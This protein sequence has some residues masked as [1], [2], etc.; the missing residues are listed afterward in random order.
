MRIIISGKHLEITEAIRDYAEKKV[1]KLKKYFD[2]IIEVD[3]TLSVENTKSEGEKHIADVLIF[4]NGTKL[5]AEATDKNLYASIDEVI[6]VLENQITKYKEKL[7]DN[8]HK[9]NV[10]FT[11]KKANKP[12]TE[13]ETIDV[14][15]EIRK[16][17]S[18]KVSTSKP[19]SV[20]EA[21]LQMEALETSFYLFL[22]PETNELNIVYKRDDGDY[23][24]VEPDWN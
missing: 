14:N 7:R 10:K 6:D 11:L 1:S 23:G 5:K 17:I 8:K 24:H 18:T 19:M 16:I 2:N 15:G 3:I 9:H 4:A 20:E 12:F 21:I 22:N 13:E